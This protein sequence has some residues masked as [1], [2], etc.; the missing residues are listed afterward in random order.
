MLE[1]ATPSR[2]PTRPS[3]LLPRL[4]F[5]GVGWIGRQRLGAIAAS[6]A[7]EIAAIFDPV[8][9]AAV[10]SA[11]LAPTAALVTSF[12]KLLALD[13]DGIVIATPSAL[14]A[15][16]TIAALQHGKAVFCQKPLAR[17]AGET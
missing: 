7:G 15:A 9:E 14:H 12:E 11:E 5:A 6:G 1:V 2:K 13:L 17:D 10:R 16:Q 4:G 8:Y 3:S